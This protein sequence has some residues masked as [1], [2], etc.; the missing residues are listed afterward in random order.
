[1]YQLPRSLRTPQTAIS[2]FIYAGKHSS[3]N[4][5]AN[6]AFKNTKYLLQKK[7]GEEK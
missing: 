6:A 1:M 7:K 3:V 4:Q 5:F 2:G